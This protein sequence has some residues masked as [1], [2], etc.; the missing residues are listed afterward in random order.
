MQHKMHST[1]S[2]GQVASIYFRLDRNVRF[3]DG[4]YYDCWNVGFVVGDHK[5]LN[6]RWWSG[7]NKKYE[8]SSTG[9]CGLEALMWA[10][11]QIFAFMSQRRSDVYQYMVIGHDDKRRGS[12]YRRLIKDGF[13]Q[14]T[15]VDGEAVLAKAF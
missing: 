15:Y 5:S 3:S 10:K 9:R 11:E 4:Y 7:R 6:N 14:Y 8:G 1:L 13:A 2:N 12:A